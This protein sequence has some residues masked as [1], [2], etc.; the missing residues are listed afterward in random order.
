M[1]ILGT[2]LDGRHWITEEAHA[3]WL[4]L[5]LTMGNGAKALS[6]AKCTRLHVPKLCVLFLLDTAVFL[7]LVEDLVNMLLDNIVVSSCSW[8]SMVVCDI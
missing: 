5:V 4:P 1:D 6:L 3:L 2:R 8:G 7:L